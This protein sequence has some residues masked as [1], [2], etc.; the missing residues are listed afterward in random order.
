[1]ENDYFKLEAL[2]ASG[3]KLLARSP[4][5]YKAAMEMSRTPTPAQ[6]FG[7]VVH[8]MVLEPHKTHSDLFSVKEL[9]WTTK[10]GKEEKA[11]LEKIGLPI[12]S[13]ADLDKALRMRDSVW[14]SKHAAELLT[15]CVTEQ[16][17]TWTGYDA[18][19]PCKGG[20]DAIG[21]AGIVDLK[22]TID[23][24]PEA[25]ARAIRS[26]GYYMQAAHYI[27]GVAETTGGIAPFTF[28]AVEKQPP[29]AVACY[30]LSN[31][32][33]AAGWSA[34]N[35]IAKIYSDCISKNEWPGYEGK[36]VELSIPINLDVATIADL[37]LEDF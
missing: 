18:K 24:S 26:Y 16:Q 36:S 17:T 20:I 7:T 37:E 8:S 33:L 27:D 13:V 6:I 28:I 19:V 4:A 9:N 5:H 29:Y 23:A 10:E 11:K 21:S 32:S 34:M 2:S 15:G 35:R 22:T 31:D 14:A 12:I 30:T 1:M 25:F 3:A